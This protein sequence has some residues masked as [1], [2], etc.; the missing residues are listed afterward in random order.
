MRDFIAGVPLARTQQQG[1]KRQRTAARHHSDTGTTPTR[2]DSGNPA[3][4]GYREHSLTL[5]NGRAIIKL[6]DVIT[7]ADFKLIM[8]VVEAHCPEMFSGW[9]GTATSDESDHH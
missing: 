2:T 8:R 5:S 6:P 1:P 7:P 3:Q 4:L 9:V